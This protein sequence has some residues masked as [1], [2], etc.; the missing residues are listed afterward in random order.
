MHDISNCSGEARLRN[1]RRKIRRAIAAQT[2]VAASAA[3]TGPGAVI[4]AAPAPGGRASNES[5]GMLPLQGMAA[6]GSSNALAVGVSDQRPSPAGDPA[7]SRDQPM[8]FTVG[9][10]SRMLSRDNSPMIT[11]SSGGAAIAAAANT[12]LLSD[13]SEF[14]FASPSLKLPGGDHDMT[15][16]GN[17]FHRL[18]DMVYPPS[19]AGPADRVHGYSADTAQVPMGSLKRKQPAAAVA[20]GAGGSDWS[21]ESPHADNLSIRAMGEVS[22]APGH[23]P[24]RPLSQHERLQQSARALAVRASAANDPLSGG[25]AFPDP[26]AL[27]ALAGWTGAPVDTLEAERSGLAFP[28][29]SNQRHASSGAPAGLANFQLGRS[30]LEDHRSL[31]EPMDSFDPSAAHRGGP[32]QRP[33]PAAGSMMYH[34]FHQQQ[35]QQPHH[36]ALTGA[37]S[38]SELMSGGASSDDIQMNPAVIALLRDA[39][40]QMQQG[41]F[42]METFIASRVRGSASGGTGSAGLHGVPQA[43]GAQAESEPEVGRPRASAIPLSRSEDGGAV[44]SHSSAQY[45]GA[46][47]A[48]HSDH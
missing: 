23:S 19:A 28:P 29:L 8:P 46:S 6:G 30:S 14:P 12:P 16:S 1:Q 42:D 17:S 48:Q 5:G 44:T 20:G 26:R 37:G 3:R 4:N 31:S 35:Q 18:P 13:R 41:T 43:G 40:S 39:W 9:G 34:P 33:Q 27:G 25:R 15:S 10:D 45:Q 32:L 7:V 11:P 21:F 47:S 38:L 24:K 22:D 2:A 36:H